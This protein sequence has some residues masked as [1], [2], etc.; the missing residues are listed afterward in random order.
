MCARLT[1]MTR[2]WNRG[3]A[4]SP[5]HSDGTTRVPIRPIGCKRTRSTLDR[6]SSGEECDAH[7][8]TSAQMHL[9]S[10]G[11]DVIAIAHNRVER[12]GRIIGKTKSISPSPSS[13]PKASRCGSAMRAAIW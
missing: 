3:Y 4:V 9:D 12:R 6:S 1:Q 13:M 8:N 11:R 10:L 2:Y 7:A 5:A